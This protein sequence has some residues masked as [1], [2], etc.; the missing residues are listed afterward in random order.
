[1]GSII[2]SA[3]PVA[4]ARGP[5]ESAA[6]Q[7]MGHGVDPCGVSMLL[8]ILGSAV[9]LQIVISSSRYR[10]A[11]P[12]SRHCHCRGRGCAACTLHCQ[13]RIQ[14]S[15]LRLLL[16][17]DHSAG[18]PCALRANGRVLHNTD[19]SLFQAA[20]T[21]W[22]LYWKQ[23]DICGRERTSSTSGTCMRQPAFR[24]T[25]VEAASIWSSREGRDR[26]IVVRLHKRT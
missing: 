2:K 15:I 17:V 23:P 19:I 7:D 18:S 5:C 16:V 3:W 12:S 6:G 9:S 25:C 1:V 20:D 4:Y 11:Y 22:I 8:W 10:P 26:V 13:P 24:L 14:Y 21:W